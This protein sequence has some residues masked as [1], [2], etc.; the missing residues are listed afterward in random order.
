MP[1]SAPSIAIA[2]PHVS[3]MFPCLGVLVFM[4]KGV[5]HRTLSVKFCITPAWQA[6]GDHLRDITRQCPPARCRQ[7]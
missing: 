1:A 6:P 7:R 2:T 5:W 3:K 4:H